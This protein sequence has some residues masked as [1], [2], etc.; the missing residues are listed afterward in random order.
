MNRSK[1]RIAEQPAGD[2]ALA[3]T[4]EGFVADVQSFLQELMEERGITRA[5]LARRL[6][7]S[8]PRITQM[9]SDE[10]RNL[11]IRLLA[12]VVHALGDRPTIGAENLQR[13]RVERRDSKT[14]ETVRLSPNVLPLWREQKPSGPSKAPP[15]DSQDARLDSLVQLAVAGGRR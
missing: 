2:Y 10:C 6:G 5:E 7:V 11:T 15:C 8:R 3:L 4:E 13:A 12:R 1:N 14:A 9:F